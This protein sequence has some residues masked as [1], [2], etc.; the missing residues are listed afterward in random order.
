M[1]FDNLFL[2]WRTLR[3]LRLIQLYR[4]IW[5]NF[6]RPYFF[7]KNNKVS[8]HFPIG[9]WRPPINRNISM[10]GKCKFRFLN[11]ARTLS[12]DDGWNQP[13][14]EKL[15]LYNL[16]YFD[17]LNAKMSFR[18]LKWHQSLI[19]KWIDQNAVGRGVG[20]EP[21]T[22]SLRIVNWI[23][24]LNNSNKP[25][26]GML[27]SLIIQTNWLERRLEWHLLGNHL[28]SNAKAL[29]FSGLFFEGAQSK[30][31]LEKGL[32][33]IRHQLPEQ[34]LLDGG[35]FEKSPMYHA[36]FL[37][38]MLD[39]VNFSLLRP[40]L[41]SESE[42]KIWRNT[43]VSMLKWLEKMTHPDKEISFFNDSALGIAPKLNELKSYAIRLG[44][45][46]VRRV[47]SKVKYTNFK[48]SGYVHFK[49]TNAEGI[50]DVGSIGPD[51]LPGHAHADTL[52][53]ELSFFGKRLIV[54]GGTSTY[55]KGS[56]RLR[57]RGTA[58]HSTVE[59]AKFN[60]S[61]V[62]DSFRVGRRAYPDDLQIIDKPGKLS[63]SCSHNGYS[64]LTDCPI[65]R[66]KWIITRKTISISDQIQGG[67]Y[68]AIARYI[69]HP[70]IKI[71]KVKDNKWIVRMP[72]NKIAT[73]K[74]L[75]GKSK[76]KNITYSPEFGKNIPTKCLMIDLTN[77]S[78][79]FEIAWD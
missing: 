11:K 2:Y 71:N 77:N 41:V 56:K 31:W 24:W 17:D 69:F 5:F 48:E 78:G 47:G 22:T 13:S 29:V 65:H 79:F 51:Y 68:S 38:D 7:L 6:Y 18:R 12:K 75:Q 73:I 4:R 62:W 72:N 37:E 54:N 40:G 16:H 26:R 39:L 8:L 10:V 30:K 49:C 35:H 34:V 64:Y 3:H 55:E 57:D 21:Y 52:S 20:W 25:V 42:V 43:V 70:D 45:K 28:F 15:W 27:N 46:E 59:V 32:D 61:E 33:I 9:Q 1:E 67:S 63:I 60:S 19:L 44:F 76:L 14:V 66:R 23:K 74:I 50:L 53:F 36:L 58:S